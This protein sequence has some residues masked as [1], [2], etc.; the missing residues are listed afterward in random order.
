MLRE[1]A[2]SGRSFSRRHASL[3]TSYCC[4]SPAQ[5]DG[6][7]PRGRRNGE[8]PGVIGVLSGG[9]VKADGPGPGRS[10]SGETHGHRQ[11]CGDLGC[12]FHEEPADVLGDL[13]DYGVPSGSNHPSGK[14][15]SHS[16][17]GTGGLQPN[18]AITPSMFAIDVWP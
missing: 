5:S 8:L 3:R 12:E 4:Q 2:L 14:P 9:A 1:R 7:N 11:S 10:G 16:T 15:I 17:S 13:R 6:L 18:F